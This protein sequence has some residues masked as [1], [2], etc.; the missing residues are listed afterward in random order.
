MGSASALTCVFAPE[1]DWPLPSLTIEEDLVDLK[2]H[3]AE[4]DRRL[5]FAYTVIWA[6][7]VELE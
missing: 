1:D 7:D 2:R 3:A 4:F 6:S 5:A